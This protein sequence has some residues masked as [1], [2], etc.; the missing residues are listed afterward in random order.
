MSAIK[1][2]KKDFSEF[3]SKNSQSDIETGKLSIRQYIIDKYKANDDVEV[4]MDGVSI[5][6]SKDETGEYQKYKNIDFTG[7]TLRKT[8][9]ENIDFENC[10]FAD[11]EMQK[12]RMVNCNF[13]N[14]N[15]SRANL[16]DG[17][18]AGGEPWE[19]FLYNMKKYVL[20]IATGATLLSGLA[21]I[22]KATKTISLASA[23]ASYIG[24]RLVHRYVIAIW[25]KPPVTTPFKAAMAVAPAAIAKGLAVVGIVAAGVTLVGAVCCGLKLIGVNFRESKIDGCDFTGAFMS[26]CN[27]DKCAIKNTKLKLV[28]ITD[29]GLDQTKFQNCDFSKAEAVHI[30]KQSNYILENCHTGKQIIKDLSALAIRAK[31]AVATKITEGKEFVKKVIAERKATKTGQQAL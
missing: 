9:F 27:F 30:K 16:S 25:P 22:A 2:T 17:L 7:V 15:M 1:V 21:S 26:S 10:S 5:S 13:K 20:P 11:C 19:Q 4:S 14:V 18:I 3:L 31:D 24:N 8:N 23:K 29:L 6:G 12:I 28:K